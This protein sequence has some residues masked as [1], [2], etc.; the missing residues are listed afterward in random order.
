MQMKKSTKLLD[1]LELSRLDDKIRELFPFG[2]TGLAPSEDT[3]LKDGI[4]HCTLTPCSVIHLRMECS[5]QRL[6]F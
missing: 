3:V 1:N 5:L 2:K 6:N 4:L